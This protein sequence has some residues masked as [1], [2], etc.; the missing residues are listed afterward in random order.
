MGRERS[1]DRNDFFG[2]AEE[3]TYDEDRGGCRNEPYG[4]CLENIHPGPML[5]LF[6]SCFPTHW[7]ESLSPVWE[8]TS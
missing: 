7:P 3:A 1:R 4:G 2:A 5:K 6:L 8:T